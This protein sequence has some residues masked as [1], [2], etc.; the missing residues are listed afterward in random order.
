MVA[1]QRQQRDA[2][3]DRCHGCDKQGQRWHLQKSMARRP[4]KGGAKG[5]KR[6]LHSFV[7]NVEHVVGIQKGAS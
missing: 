3:L 4:D 6:V 1:M 7:H 5:E 2:R